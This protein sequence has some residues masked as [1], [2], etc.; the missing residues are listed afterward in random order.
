MFHLENVKINVN[1][2]EEAEHFREKVE[3]LLIF[4]KKK[5]PLQILFVTKSSDVDL[6]EQQNKENTHWCS[7]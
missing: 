5:I 1:R 2:E 3:T 6:K 4:T 7:S